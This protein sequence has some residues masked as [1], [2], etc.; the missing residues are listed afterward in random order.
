LVMLDLIMPRMDGFE[1]LRRMKAD[2]HLKGIPVIVLTADKSAELKALQMGAAD[3]ITKPF[4]IHEI[5]LA[6]AGRIIELSE[7]R[8]L[9]SSAEHDRLTGLYN[10]NFF[11]EYAERL[12]VYHKQLHL[13]AV[14]L[15]VE[16]FHLL[17]ETS[18][19]EFGDEVL[20]VIGS[21]IR[22][23]LSGSEGIACRFD[24]DQFEIYCAHQD[25]YREL[26]D[27]VQES[28]DRLSASVS[29][30]LRMGVYLREEGVEP[31]LMFDRARAACNHARGDYQNPYVVYDESM[32]NREMLN[33]RL[34][35]DFRKAVDERQLCVFYQPKYD[36]RTEPARLTSAEALIRWKHPE[37][38]MISPG[39]FVPLFE[40]NGLISA[41][42]AFVWK[43]AAGQIAK[44]K[45]TYGVSVPVSVN[46]S[47]ADVFDPQLVDNLV[48]LIERNGLRFRDLKLEVTESAYTDN[49]KQLLDVVSRLRGLGFEIEMD[50][51][52]SGYSSLNM[53]SSMP[54]DVL[55]M[56]MK[57]VRDIERSE[58]DLRLVEL[59][60]DIAK[61][62]GVPVVAEGVE[63]EG[64]LRI[65][66]NAGCQIVQGY[67]FSKPLPAEE[68][69]KRIEQDL[70]L[71]KEE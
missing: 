53:L 41:V 49:A 13:D 37:L 60:L 28:L 33:Q 24:A 50:D 15:D 62:L 54:I 23:F 32:R 9:I 29:I 20:R 40:A 36:I 65:L 5:I 42:D 70:E 1:V 64:Q 52:G 39:V 46:L 67:Y 71:A 2:E 51:F 56:D 59:I 4:D 58:T 3:F 38:G 22:M 10:R 18:G 69:E 19:R 21:E 14:F 47:R 43:E 16:Q 12:Y 8:Q 30:R 61:Y 34:L 35:N 66:R 55:K 7:G 57:F 6:R 17:N 48:N 31:V 44:W 25:G 11:Y 63:T 45:E 68:F 27:R 26:L